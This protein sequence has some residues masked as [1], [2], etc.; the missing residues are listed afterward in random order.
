MDTVYILFRI[1]FNSEHEFCGAYSSKEAAQE[2]ANRFKDERWDIEET[3]LDN[4]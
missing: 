3:T 2:Y 1:N 4:P